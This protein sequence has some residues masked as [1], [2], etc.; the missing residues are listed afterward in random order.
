[1]KKY[2]GIDGIEFTDNDIEKWAAEAESDH[3]YS[4]DHL[5]PAVPGRPISV[6]AEAKPFTIRLDV[7]R[8]AKLNSIAKQRHMTASDLMRDLIDKL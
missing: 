1:M 8:R 7:N 4:G 3:G 6:G 5:G 2:T